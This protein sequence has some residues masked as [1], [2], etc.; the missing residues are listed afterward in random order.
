M[1]QIDNRNHPDNVPGMRIELIAA[2]TIEGVIDGV[3][4]RLAL[5][6]RTFLHPVVATHKGW[7]GFA[8]FNRSM[9]DISTGLT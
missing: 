8:M 6:W 1:G 4:A 2:E 9:R 7:S 5:G 3:N